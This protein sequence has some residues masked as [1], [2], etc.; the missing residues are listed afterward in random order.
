MHVEVDDSAKQT[1]IPKKCSAKNS[2]CFTSETSSLL[3]VTQDHTLFMH[4]TI[5]W[6]QLV[7]T[8]KFSHLTLTFK[9]MTDRYSTYSN[10]TGPSAS[11]NIINQS[12]KVRVIHPKIIDSEYCGVLKPET[13]KRVKWPELLA[14]LTTTEPYILI[15][16]K[17]W[18]NNNK[19][20]I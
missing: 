7:P 16:D 8:S 3:N 17:I 12:Q 4:K 10:R 20:I 6:I 18:G 19:K 2:Y 14:S 13:S 5:A 11:P 9:N 15:L 1:S